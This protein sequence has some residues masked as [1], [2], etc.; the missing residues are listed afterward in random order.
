M[1][2]PPFDHEAI[3]GQVQDPLTGIFR[4][5]LLKIQDVFIL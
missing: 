1:L 2:F 3:T 4:A 5:D